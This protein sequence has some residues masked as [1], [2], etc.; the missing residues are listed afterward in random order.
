M[1]SSYVLGIEPRWAN[2]LPTSCICSPGHKVGREQATDRD[3]KEEDYPQRRY[4]VLEARG[5]RGAHTGFLESAAVPPKEWVEVGLLLM[6]QKVRS[7][8]DLSPGISRWCGMSSRDRVAQ[9]A[10]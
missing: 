4:R 10:R 2:S 6:L 1:V 3:S 7:H 5:R 8:S 9:S